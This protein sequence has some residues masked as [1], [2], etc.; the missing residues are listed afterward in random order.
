MDELEVR[1]AEQQKQKFTRKN[2]AIYEAQRRQEKKRSR[3]TAFYV[4]LFIAI[5]LVF[6]AVCVSVFLNVEEVTV[7][8]LEKYSYEE[9]IEYVPINIGDNMFSFKSKDIEADIVRALPYVGSVEI[10]RDLPTTVVINVIE[11]K[12]YFAAE[13]AGDVYLMSSNL[14]VLEKITDVENNQE[15]KDLTTLHLNSVRRCIVGSRIEFVDKRTLD[16]LTDLYTCFADNYI[17]SKIVSVDVRSRFDLYINYEGR[18]EVY[19]GDIENIDI[20]IRFLIGIIDELGDDAK[21]KID[22]SNHREAAVALS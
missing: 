9:I 5:T 15:I 19:L 1:D 21:G 20:K 17:E 3:R 4:F 18:F 13:L 12:P 2:M 11:E 8:G 22:V 10:K 6:L 14:K 7:E 16:A